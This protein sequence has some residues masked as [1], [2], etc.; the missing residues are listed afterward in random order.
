M[1]GFFLNVVS[2]LT[3][4]VFKYTSTEPAEEIE[5]IFKNILQQIATKLVEKIE[6]QLMW[7]YVTW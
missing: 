1:I 5:L 2:A 3:E 4:L 7:K 6:N